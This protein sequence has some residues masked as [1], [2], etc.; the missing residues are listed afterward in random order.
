M[1]P[2]EVIYIQEEIEQEWGQVKA[3]IKTGRR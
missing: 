1:L 2:Y 3:P